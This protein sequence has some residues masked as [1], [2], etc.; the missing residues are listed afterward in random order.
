MH[1]SKPKC[2]LLLLFNYA[3]MGLFAEALS[4]IMIHWNYFSV[5]TIFT[6]KIDR[7]SR[8]QRTSCYI[9]LISSNDVRSESPDIGLF[10][11]LDIPNSYQKVLT[12]IFTLQD[13]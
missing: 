4:R 5:R 9:V 2:L 6:T 7:W 13:Y 12:L 3:I 8:T 1:F 11:N 10:F